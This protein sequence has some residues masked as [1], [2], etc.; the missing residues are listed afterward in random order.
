MSKRSPLWSCLVASV[1]L[2]GPACASS[3]PKPALAEEAEL[4]DKDQGDD[5]PSGVKPHHVDCDPNQPDMPCTPD[6]VPP[7]LEPQR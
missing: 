5:D 4:P 1:A 6:M 3:R 7:E 2:A